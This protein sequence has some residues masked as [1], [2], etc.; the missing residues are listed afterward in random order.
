MLI[1]S[2]GAIALGRGLLGL[3]T[4]ALALEEKRAAQAVLRQRIDKVVAKSSG[5]GSDN[6]RGG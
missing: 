1:V 3:G 4:R 6:S 2:S 5:K